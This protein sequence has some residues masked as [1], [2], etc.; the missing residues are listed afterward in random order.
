MNC[1]MVGRSIPLYFYGE[2][3][4]EEEERMEDHLESC[5]ACRQEMERHK[6]LSQALDRR[7]LEPPA[8][9][10][11]ECRHDLMRAI[12][13]DEAPGAARSAARAWPLCSKASTGLFAG[14]FSRFR[15]LL[16]RG[17]AAGP[18]IFLRPPHHAFPATR[19]IL[20]G[21]LPI[22]GS[23]PSSARCSR[24][25]PDRYRHRH[26]RNPAA[27]HLGQPERWQYSAPAAGGAREQATRPCGWNRWIC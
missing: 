11:A 25:R 5:A 15:L 3:S 10:L 7:E 4:L 22:R 16:R 26:R 23:S 14:P 18:G 24:M 6:L 13:R 12:Y 8:A 17:G 21:R 9:L 1:E 20:A 27:G 2:L 19:G